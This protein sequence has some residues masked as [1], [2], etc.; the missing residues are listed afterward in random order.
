MSRSRRPNARL[1]VRDLESRLA[2]AVF[3]AG[4][5]GAL[6]ITQ[7]PAAVTPTPKVTPTAATPTVQ[8]AAAAAPI[9]TPG[10]ILSIIRGQG[11]VYQTVTKNW[12]DG[13][14]INI[15][16]KNDGAKD[17]FGWRVEFDAPFTITNWWN[18]QLISQVGNHYVFKN[19]PNNYNAV[20]KPGQTIQFGFNTAFETG[21]PTYI[22]AFTL[23]N[24]Q[25]DNG[26]NTGGSTTGTIGQRIRSDWGTGATTDVTIQNS[27][28]STMIGWTV[29][30]DAPFTITDVWNAQLVSH[31]GNHYVF[32]NIPG[33]FNTRIKA[34]GTATFGFNAVFDAGTSRTLQ[35]VVLNGNAAGNGGGNNGG[36]GGGG[37]TGGSTTGTF[38]QAITS[39]WGDGA[40]NIITVR[41]TGA[42]TMKGWTVEFDAG[43]SIAEVWNAQ[44]VSRTAVPGGG[45]HYVFQNTPGLFNAL[46]P[47]NGTATFGFNSAFTFGAVTSIL[48]PRLNGTAIGGGSTGPGG[49]TGGSTTGAV[50][51]SI[52]SQF[53]TGATLSVGIQNTGTTSMQGWTVE[54][55]APFTITNSWNAQLVSTTPIGNGSFHY[56]FQNIPNFWNANILAGA[57]VSFGFNTSYPAGTVL[58]LTNGKLNGTAITIGAGSNNGGGNNGGG[59]NNGSTTGTV[60]QV[61]RNQSITG[62]TNDVTIRNTGTTAMTGWTVEFDASFQVTD[63]WNVQLVSNASTGNGTYHYVFQSIPGSAFANILAGGTR[64]FGFNTALTPDSNRT[65]LNTKLNGVLVGNN[66]AGGTTDFGGNGGGNN[67]GGN[68]G[69]G[70]TG[71]S[72]TGFVQQTLRNLLTQSAT[73]DVTIK[74]TGTT[75]MNGWTVEFDAPF[76]VTD[77][78][79]SQLVSNA[80]IGNGMFH[81]VFQNSPGL[82]NSNIPAN[83]TASFGFNMT[84]AAGANPTMFA[85]KLAGLLVGNNGAGG[86]IDFGGN[87]GGGNNGGGGTDQNFVATI[88][89]TAQS[90]GPGS[91]ANLTIHNN[92]TTAING[93][94][95]E[96][97]A[98]FTLT[99]EFWNATLV[100]ST[101]NVGGGYHYKF[102]NKPN[103]FNANIPAGGTATFGFNLMYATG[104]TT[105][106]VTGLKLNGKAV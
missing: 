56:V 76:T 15:N 17:I 97:D 42:T 5:A 89:Q 73:S 6:A 93:W 37:N 104:T 96:F 67:G 63:F 38:S 72:T 61:I 49:N 79:N 23:N 98:P 51:Q 95:V 57:T 88:T 11:V 77:F 10:G 100:S 64:M 46:I 13:A 35:N 29:A 33:L 50:T 78:W 32:Q 20:I 55:D 45:F 106:A 54:F 103:F 40:T 105:A 4:N 27:G 82:F 71:G 12:G 68:N 87:N 9:G 91:T 83:G 25:P 66:G 85:T 69:G 84:F 101:P 90:F 99:S 31:S 16:V 58:N 1:S 30:F 65:M 22:S 18:A 3:T 41:N 26:G 21:T 24:H 60:L 86:T 52:T 92:G 8:T 62:T 47:P 74:N 28:S 53:G 14:S 36:G 70:N 7:Q 43:F 34:G 102:N 94:T 59:N 75:T 2:P 44:L 48:N 39:N 80:S 81:Y 19:I